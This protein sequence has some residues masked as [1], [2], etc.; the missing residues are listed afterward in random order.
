MLIRNGRV[1]DP[2]QNIDR[3]ATVAIREGKIAEIGDLKNVTAD[4]DID[5]SGF[6]VCPG[7]IDMHV[8]LRA[9]G[10]EEAETID[11]GTAAA[12]AGG[13]TAIACMPNTKPALDNATMIRGVLHEAAQSAHCRVYPI[14]AITKGRRGEELADIELMRE[15]GAVAFS[16]DGDGIQDAGV[17]FKAMQYM[18]GSDSLFIQHCEDR[19]LAAG[20]CVHAGA[21]ADRLGLPGLPALAEEVMVQRD[22]QLARGAGTRYHMCHISTAGAVEIIRRAKADGIAATTEVCPHHLLLTDKE[23]ERFDANWKMNPPLRTQEDVDACLAGVRDG[24]IDCLITDH[25]PHP[26]ETKSLPL[27]EAS[28]GIVGL[29]TALGLFIKALIDPEIIGWPRL[30]HAMSTAPAEILRV[31]GGTLQKNAPADITLIDPQRKWTVDANAFRSKSRNTPFDGWKLRGKAVMT[32]VG[33]V[34]KFSEL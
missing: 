17:C 31:P 19:S 9:P 8:H 15:A 29:E 21:V 22:V 14:G 2:S 25:A 7:L 10:M 32:I 16:D 26:P 20:G 1:I 11:S 6:I 24:T 30:V 34:K 5:A 23:C 13:F 18:S 28:F 27:E 4:N 33:G 12:V 3:V